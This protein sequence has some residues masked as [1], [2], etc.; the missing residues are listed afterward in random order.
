MRF[1]AVL[2]GIGLA[3]AYWDTIQNY[4]D[5]WTRPHAAV[6]EESDTEYFCPCIR[7]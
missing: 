2:V 7:R 1:I 4:W 6:A 3:I 5:R